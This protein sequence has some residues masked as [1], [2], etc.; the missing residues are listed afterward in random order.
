MSQE[1]EKITTSARRSIVSRMFLYICLTLILVGGVAGGLLYSI[2]FEREVEREHQE[3]MRITNTFKPAIAHALW[4]YDKQQLRLLVA[5][6]QGD[7]GVSYVRAVDTDNFSAEAG[8]RP[9]HAHVTRIPVHYDDLLVGDLSVAYFNGSPWMKAFENASPYIGSIFLLM[10]ALAGTLAFVLHQ[11]VTRRI[12][13]LARAVNSRIEHGILTPVDISPSRAMDDVDQLMVAF[14]EL[15]EQLIKELERNKL[16]QHQLS[17]VNAELEDRVEE[18]TQHLSETIAQL[19]QTVDE[20]NTT[21]SQLI[22]A[23]K[24][25]ALGG[26]I[27]GIGHE[28]ETPLGLCLTMESCLRNDVQ[29]VIAEHP[30]L[31]KTEEWSRVSESLELLRENLRRATSL[32]KSFKS[33]SAGH[34]NDDNDWIYIHNTISDLLRSLS[35]MLRN[36]PY[37]V[38]VDCPEDICMQASPTAITQVLTNLITNSL[39]H[40]FAG[41]TEGLIVISVKEDSHN[42]IMEYQD[43]GI[44]LSREAAKK[45]FEPMFTTC[46]SDGGTGLGMHLVYNIIKQRMKGDI[47]IEPSDTGVH[48]RMVMPVS[49]AQRRDKGRQAIY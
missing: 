45:I 39:K 7:P 31:V 30:E 23:E 46:R 4:Q 36:H 14:R 25:S 13:R 5:G 38:K 18:R 44:G 47:S 20:L 16:A 3:M 12:T 27:A 10:L 17:Q 32:M 2:Q 40:G 41:R 6:L 34:I 19:N 33:V 24:Q 22:E 37:E 29:A 43:D 1:S 35:P 15:N 21:Q 49:K 28:I 9:Y 26:M 42:V 48:F 11:I 8:T